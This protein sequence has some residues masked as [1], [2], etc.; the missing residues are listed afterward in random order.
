MGS[1]ILPA[2]S[3]LSWQVLSMS[4]REGSQGWGC[5]R[6]REVRTCV[7]SLARKECAGPAET[8]CSFRRL[9]VSAWQEGPGGLAFP[10]ALLTR[11][12]AEQ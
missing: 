3:S 7:H 1:P 8:G 9:H 6:G 12:V 11:E 2:P 4:R 5:G 10:A